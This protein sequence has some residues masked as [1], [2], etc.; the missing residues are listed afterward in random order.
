MLRIG[1]ATASIV[2]DRPAMLQGQMNVRVARFALDDITLN[3]MALDNGN[4]EDAAILISCD[5]ALI[6]EE[7]LVD[8]RAILAKTIP[9]F[10]GRHLV[11]FATHT[12]TS[13]VYAGDFYMHPGGEVMTVKECHAFLARR[14]ADVALRA[15]NDRAPGKCARA[16]GHAV[17]GHNR[18]PQYTDGSTQ[19]YGNAARPDF[20]WIEGYEDHSVDIL[21]TWDNAGRLAGVTLV[22][23]CPSQVDEHLESFS[24]DFWH[25]TRVEL[26]RRHGASLNVLGVC[27]AAGDQSPHFIVLK[28]QEAEMRKRRGVSER[29][30]IALRLADAVDRA[31]ACTKPIEGVVA[32]KHEIREVA[33][34]PRKVSKEERDACVKLRADA[35]TRLNPKS[36][37]PELLQRSID[38]HDS[39]LN[40]APFVTELHALRIG[41]AVIA[42]NPFELF[43]DYGMR[44]K[45]RSSAGQTFVAQLTNGTGMYLPTTR[46]VRGGGYGAMPAVCNVGP[47]GGDELVEHTLA[48]IDLVMAE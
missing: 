19:M 21:F 26:R 17:V 37:W 6:S 41:D 9:E 33:L 2:P 3:A 24:A 23:P 34:T 48:M 5:V 46:A 30:E 29:Q 8:A 22:V 7:L 18:R 16:F 14:V 45:A 4:I 12:H 1:Y 10:I 13:L 43:V 11:L 32:L 25:E 31:L 20:A 47:E 15:W 38:V 39:K 27:G 35:I 36:W 42:T 44:I 28:K 40:P